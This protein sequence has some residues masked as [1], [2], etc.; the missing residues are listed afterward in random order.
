MCTH[1]H[2][3]IEGWA[4][5]GHIFGLGSCSQAN[6]C[7]AEGSKFVP[8]VLNWGSS[9][10]MASK[11]ENSGGALVGAGSHQLDNGSKGTPLWKSVEPNCNLSMHTCLDCCQKAHS[12]LHRSTSKCTHMSFGQT[13]IPS[14]KE[15][16][17]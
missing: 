5:T 13:L 7:I 14:S 4:C 9:N 8:G 1:R 17:R 16:W 11:W 12:S 3:T 6:L 10:F 2:T 15:D